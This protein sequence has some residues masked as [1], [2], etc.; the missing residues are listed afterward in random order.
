M[1]WLGLEG[2]SVIVTG[3]AA[4]IGRACCE[5]FL[6]VGARVVVADVAQETGERAVEEMKAESGGEAVF[7]R[8]DVTDRKDMENMVATAVGEFGT[9]DIL[10][11]NA[12]ILI[13]RLVVDPA[14]REE[15]T[16]QILD[17]MLA[18][19]QKG[20]FLATQAAVREMIRAGHGGV[21]LNMA[22]ESGLEGSE[23]QS[24]YAAT[25]GAIYSMTR[26]WAKEFGKHGVRV[27]GIAP[28][29]IE[30]TALRSEEYERAVAYTRGISVEEFRAK[31]ENVSIPL[32]RVGK[33]SEVADVA[34]Y[35]ASDR[36][37]YIHGTTINVTGGKS[38]A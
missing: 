12:G 1:S 8:A 2:K 27:V 7:A 18:I 20:Y 9:V 14:D 19:N 32:G 23:G 30:A 24:V 35:L 5:A 13:P 29:I 22:S 28:G 6:G 4:G 21:V 37:S 31:Y 15:L 34:C 17:K 36:A 16:E 11:N 10:L 38:R 33:L 26:S 25:K 3:G